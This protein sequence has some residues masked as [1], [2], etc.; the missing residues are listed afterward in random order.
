MQYVRRLLPTDA[1]VRLAI[2]PALAFIA[3]TAHHQYLFDFWHHLARGREIVNRGQLLNHDIF[4]YTVAGQEFRDANW[5]SQVLYYLLYQAGGLDLVLVVNSLTVALTILLVVLF[6]WQR[7]ESLGIASAV[8]TLVFLG[9]W[10]VLTLRPQTFSLLLF[11]LIYWALDR[12]RRQPRW[13][14]VPPVLI[15]LWTNLHGAFPAGVLLVGCYLLATLWQA[16]RASR[17]RRDPASWQFGGCLA[18]SVLATL[19]NPYGWGIYHYVGLTSN[20]AAA[21]GIV[22]WLPP[23]LDLALG[24]AF[25][26]SLLLL[27]GLSTLLWLRQRRYP[28]AQDVLLL[29]CFGLLAGRSMRMVV[30]W[31]LVVAPVLTTLLASLRR[32]PEPGPARRSQPGL[33]PALVFAAILL[34]VF[35][36]LPGLAQY[37]PLLRNAHPNSSSTE[38]NLDLVRQQLQAESSSGRIFT[39]F[40]WGEYLSW[41]ASPQFSVFMDGRIEI[42]PDDVWQQ[43]IDLTSGHDDW[44]QILDQYQV[45][46]LVLDT[47]YHADNG[48]LDRVEHS[49]QWRKVLPVHDEIVLYRRSAAQV[50]AR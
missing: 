19:V 9:S 21:R 2:A 20:R 35:F 45:D 49:T 38:A 34:A 15:A 47:Q 46:F 10:Q 31:L 39:R 4:T 50:A 30:W 44:Q 28:G 3:L 40:E 5:L 24:W 27:V 29:L 23:S 42:Y 8:G 18:A 17:L 36:C 48:L 22:E 1:W 32:A 13:L 26:V 14:M 7:S 37:N 16:W 33:A 41:S 6:C 25:G 12:A 43:Y 11:V